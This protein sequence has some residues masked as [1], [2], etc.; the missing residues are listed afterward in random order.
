MFKKWDREV[1]IGLLWLTIGTSGGRL[2][3]R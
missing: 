1:W 2:W 3:M